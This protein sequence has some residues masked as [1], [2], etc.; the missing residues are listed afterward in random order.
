MF[1]LVPT[2]KQGLSD[3]AFQEAP[4]EVAAHSVIDEATGRLDLTT[5]L[6]LEHNILIPPAHE[7]HHPHQQQQ[8]QLWS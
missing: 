6:V 7:Q 2:D 1:T 8:Q 4:V 5:R 3:V